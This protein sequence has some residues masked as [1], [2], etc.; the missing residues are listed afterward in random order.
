MTLYWIAFAVFC[1]IH[2]VAC[3]L[4]KDIVRK[5]TKVFLIPFLAVGVLLT[6]TFHPLLLIGLFLGWLGDIFLIFTGK[7]WSFVLGASFF[8]LGH[9]SYICATLQLFLKIHTIWDIPILLWICFGYLV[10]G[11]FVAAHKTLRSHIGDLAYLGAAYF[12]VLMGALL[13]SI[14]VGNYI[15]TAAFAV[16]VLSDTVLSVC[17]FA[18]TVKRQHFYIMLT[19]LLAQTLICISFIYG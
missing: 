18:K 8:M 19:Y 12:S 14:A 2:L 10:F 4:E 16:F 13:L 11:L 5:V 7:K 6:K 15:L 3:F 17:R 1:T 9:F